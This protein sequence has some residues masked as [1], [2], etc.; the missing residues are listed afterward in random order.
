MLRDRALLIIL[1]FLAI[2]YHAFCWGFF[3][4]KQMNY[5][6]VFLLPPAMISF[7]K[8]NID[9]LAE[10]AIDPDKR[11]Y[12]IPEE[13]PRHYIDMDQYGSF[14]F[15][16]L[17][18]HWGDAIQHYSEDTLIAHGIAH[19]LGHNHFSDSEWKKMQAIEQKLLKTTKMNDEIIKK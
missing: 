13:G 18:Q 17:P 10:H 9:F 11:R 4:H 15:D 14:P 6:A 2:P 16:N 8:Q 19:L 12:A 5:D 3:A 1:L 7:Y